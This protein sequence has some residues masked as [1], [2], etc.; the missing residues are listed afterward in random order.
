M[1]SSVQLATLLVRMTVRELVGEISL[2]ICFVVHLRELFHITFK[3]L[4]MQ[5]IF[6]LDSWCN[7]P[8][9]WVLM[10]VFALHSF[11]L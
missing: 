4:S 7:K 11:A 2:L 6:D 8:L 5:R 3:E 9:L 1:Y 10:T